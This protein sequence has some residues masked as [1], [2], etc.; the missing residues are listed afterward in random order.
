[1]GKRWR[2]QPHDSG[3]IQHLQQ[4]T[5]VA[6]VVA[7][8]LV[9][10]GITAPDVASDFLAARMSDLRDPDLLPGISEAA[11]RMHRAVVAGRK[12]TVYGDYDADG[13]T[14]T[15]LLLRGLRLLGAQVDSYVPN[16]LEEG[17]G[18][19]LE[20]LQR[21]AGQGTQLLVTVDCGIASI[22]EAEK[23]RELG[24]ELII[25]DHHEFAARLPA[26]DTVV[27]PRMP[28]CDYPFSGLCGAGV[29]F[30]LMWSICQR[31]SRARRVTDRLRNFLLSAVG[32]AAIGTVA[33]V[34][35]L[36]DE[37]RVLVRH[38]LTTLKSHAPPGV[39][40]LLQLT[41]LAEKRRLGSDDIAFKL[42][43]R[44][45]AAGR[46]GQAQLAVELLATDSAPRAEELAEFIEQFNSRRIS[47]ER[48][49]LQAAQQQIQQ[50]FDAEDD[51]A[52]VL[53]GRDWHPGVIGIVAGRLAE[54]YHRPVIVLA[55]DQL[56]VRSATGSGRGIPGFNLH[57][58]LTDCSHHLVTHGGHAAAA[59]L[60]VDET[61]IDAFRRDFC[62]YVAERLSAA[63]RVPQLMID[64]EAPLAQLTLRTLEQLEQLAPFGQD[65]PRPTLCA[66]QVQLG[67]PPR[68]MGQGD[69]HLSL[70]LE[71]GPVRLRGVA[72]HRAE[73]AAPMQAADGPLDIAFCP[74]I[75][76]YAGRR[77][78]E[79]QLLDWQPAGQ[80]ASLPA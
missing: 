7:Q 8:L 53:A 25:T 13:M 11:E 46:L 3:A 36:L 67:Q 60:Q 52:F 28:D 44:L 38:G 34:V 54:Q 71:Q 20:A 55:L 59:G 27:H 68:P 49:I 35:P 33:D 76:E 32:L 58:A 5:G 15:A 16:R 56:G 45:N 31:S 66:R 14:G 65:H 18:L 6:A 41:G 51:P 42:A 47:L 21:L 63:N 29:A 69:R 40:A 72:F 24:L 64:A 12:I 23:A 79:L 57:Q 61:R 75:N 2:F 17:Y 39:A 50:Q 9:S 30:K 62:D 1:M 77:S 73:W 19:N 26:A 10:R 70:V 78:V 80:V 74:L 48:S 4:R 37:N 22:A 43:P